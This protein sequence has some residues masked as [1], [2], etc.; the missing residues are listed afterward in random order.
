MEEKAQR[1]RDEKEREKEEERKADERF[2]QS[3]DAEK[4]RPKSAAGKKVAV[5]GSNAVLEDTPEDLPPPPPAPVVQK[6]P[7]PVIE[8]PA[9][10]TPTMTV[11]LSFYII[12]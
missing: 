6:S 1:I 7:E 12:S 9:I 5:A 2:K 8:S 10:T 3:L 11:S 4:A